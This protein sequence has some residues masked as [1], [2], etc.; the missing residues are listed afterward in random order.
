MKKLLIASA[1]SAAF[2]AP[3]LA[4]AQAARAP[5]LGQVLDASGINVS[6]YIDAG[7]SYANRN[8]E[9][10]GFSDRV[11][12]SQNNSFALHQFG[13]TVAKQPSRGFGGVVN[14][15]VGS[16]AQFIH[17]F[18]E[19]V[20]TNTF[21]LTQ[22]YGQYAGGGLTLMAGKFTTL[23]GTE[24]I[25]S[26]GNMNFTRS[27]LF[28][29]IPFTHTGVR[30][31]YALGDIVTL[32]GGINNGWDQLTDANKGK[33]IELGASIIPIK[34]LTINVS[35]YFGKESAVAP[36]TPGV[37]AQD[38][39]NLLN[40]VAT[41]TINNAMS[42]GGEILYVNQDRP[43]GGA[44]KY[45]GVAG[46]FAFNFTS[47]WRVAARAEMFDDKNGF[48]FAPAAPF[49]TSDTKY[50]EVTATLAYLPN[51]SVELRGEIR[52]D[53]ANNAVFRNSDNTTAKSLLT[54]GFQ[55]IYKF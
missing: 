49:A 16:D 1:V 43:V 20:S 13:L 28:G 36:G 34:P 22:A 9:A 18:P 6:G 11:F 25:A 30:A 33:T 23:A 12:D 14:I 5:T 31:G 3:S 46:Y 41:Y 44:V 4:L 51:S 42:A 55:G 17:S 32:Y 54:L 27:M 15:T 37:G 21:D 29:A 45:N 24:V 50:K 8:V 7:Y 52:G 47:Q 10:G 53:Q 26:T 2:A 48:H 40:V 19:G 35:G 39:R 38:T